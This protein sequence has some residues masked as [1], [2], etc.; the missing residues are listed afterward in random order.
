MRSHKNIHLLAGLI[1]FVFVWP[2]VYQDVHRVLHR[3]CHA[4]DEACSTD[5][6]GEKSCAIC[7]FS[8]YLITLHDHTNVIAVFRTA[9][10]HQIFFLQNEPQFQKLRLQFPRAPPLL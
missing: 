4:A 8:F 6:E 10:Q 9:K 1:L 5:Q 7:D 2:H 3:S